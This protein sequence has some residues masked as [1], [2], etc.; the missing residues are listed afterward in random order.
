MIARRSV[1]IIGL[2]M[3]GEERLRAL[4]SLAR[5]GRPIEITGVLD[6]NFSLSRLSS[7]N[8][9]IHPF[10]SLGALLE[11]PPEWVVVATPHD[12]AVEIALQCIDRGCKV[13]IEKPMGRTLHEAEKLAEVSSRSS[14][15]LWVG[16]NYRYFKGLA[17]MLAD[18]RRGWF[19]KVLS[20]GMVLGHGGSPEMQ[21]SWK[22]DANRAGGGALLDPGIHLIDLCQLISGGGLEVLGAWSVGG[23]WNNQT[24]EECHVILRRSGMLINL[25]ASLI[26]WRSTFRVE[27]QGTDGYGVVTGRSR[28]YGA[29][30]YRRGMRWGWQGGASQAQTEEEV[31]VTDGETVFADELDAILF[32]A[33]P[34]GVMPCTSVEALEVMRLIESIRMKM[35]RAG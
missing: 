29:Q 28:S 21:N 23:F 13:L 15:P 16:L 20:V 3:M 14:M 35:S 11:R 18:V 6:P 2:G 31:V 1:A 24:E 25:Q 10:G 19:G 8:G 22:M 27:I 4:H 32:G 7:E 17:A 5:Q 33:S 26:R 30:I 12:V 9:D 34:A